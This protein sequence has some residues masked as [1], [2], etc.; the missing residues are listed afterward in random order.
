MIYDENHSKGG[1][2]FILLSHRNIARRR[3]IATYIGGLG[4]CNGSNEIFLDD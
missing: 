2:F 3:G 1:F 4:T